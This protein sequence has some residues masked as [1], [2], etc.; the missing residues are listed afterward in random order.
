MP[1][2]K[3]GENKEKCEAFL[4]DTETVFT[5]EKLINYKIP[6]SIIRV[7]RTGAERLFSGA[8]SPDQTYIHFAVLNIERISLEF[9]IDDVERIIALSANDR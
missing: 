3:G 6:G 4:L 2:A 5:E 1:I 9:E 7:P 8:L